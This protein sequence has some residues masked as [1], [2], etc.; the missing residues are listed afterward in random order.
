MGSVT[1][2]AINGGRRYRVRYQT[3]D[4]RQTDKRGFRTQ[5]DT[6]QF[7]ASVEVS[8]GRGEWVDPTLSRVS[9]RTWSDVWIAARA[10]LKPSTRSAYEWLLTKYVLPK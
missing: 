3:P 6:E 1:A 4:R 8:M 7:L 10:N 5:H 2:Y 9:V